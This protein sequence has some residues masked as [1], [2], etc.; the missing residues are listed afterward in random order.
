MILCGSRNL[1][2]NRT[3]RRYTVYVVVPRQAQ[4]NLQLQRNVFR[5]EVINSEIGRICVCNIRPN[6]VI[7]S[8]MCFQYTT[9]LR[10]NVVYV[11]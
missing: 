8:Y 3:G 10:H 5:I 9:K 4:S 2:C 1:I 11:F 7:M 6:Y